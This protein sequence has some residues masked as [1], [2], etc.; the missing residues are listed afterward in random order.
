MDF[1]TYQDA[2]DFLKDNTS[3]DDSGCWIW[4]HNLT[5]AGYGNWHG[6][7]LGDKV[8]GSHRLAA[9]INPVDESIQAPPYKLH[10]SHTCHNPAC[11]NPFHIIF[12]TSKENFQRSYPIYYAAMKKRWDHPDW[13]RRMREVNY[14]IKKHKL[15]MELAQ[16]IRR[17]YANGDVRL[18]DLADQYGVTISSISRIV[19]NQA[20]I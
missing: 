2:F 3:V 18:V 10:A 14:Y 11:C 6:Y 16:E 4:D 15:N 5:T 17:K 8:W 20:W 13:K 19:N 9:C 12:E 7:V 1:T